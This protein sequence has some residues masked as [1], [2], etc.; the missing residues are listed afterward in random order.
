[1]HRRLCRFCPDRE[2]ARESRELTRI[3][4][5][6]REVT[7]KLQISELRLPA[8]SSSAMSGF[9]DI[10]V[11]RGQDITIRDFSTSSVALLEMTGGFYERAL[12]EMAHTVAE[13]RFRD[14]GV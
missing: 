9:A 3:L 4:A 13:P 14:A 7:T 8:M 11:I 1:M 2:T 12:H 10:R 5:S 6:F